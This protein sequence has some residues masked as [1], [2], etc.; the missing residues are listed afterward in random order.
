MKD[1]LEKSAE[2]NSICA[3]VRETIKKQEELISY[4]T[5]C[6]IEKWARE[7][8]VEIPEQPQYPE[9]PIKADEKEVKDAWDANKRYKYL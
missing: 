1:D 7:N 4:T 9:S 8:S 6:S 3:W 2:M 5:A